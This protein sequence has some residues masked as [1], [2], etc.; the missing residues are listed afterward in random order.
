MA[1]FAN[2]NILCSVPNTNLA[3]DTF[4]NLKQLMK[5]AGWT[6]LSSSDGT[7][8]SSSADII[9][10]AGSGANGMNNNNAWFR[11][12]D[13][14]LTREFVFQNKPS[15]GTMFAVIKYSRQTKFNG[16]TPSA[17][18][19]PTTGGGDGVVILGSGGDV[20]S[21]TAVAFASTSGSAARIHLI[22]ESSPINGVYYWHLAV[23]QT[24]T[25]TLLSFFAHDYVSP[26][27]CSDNDND[28]SYFV[29][30]RNFTDFTYNLMSATTGTSVGA[31]KCWY[32]YGL[33][34]S[35]FDGN[36]NVYGGMYGTYTTFN[37]ASAQYQMRVPSYGPFPLST[38]PYDNKDNIIPLPIFSYSSTANTAS[39]WKGLSGAIKGV[40]VG[41]VYPEL[42][43]KGSSSSYLYMPTFPSFTGTIVIPWTTDNVDPS[44]SS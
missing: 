41:R 29:C 5:S 1:R 40:F 24:T 39:F 34:G 17:T 35:N 37:A 22:C 6:V 32:K 38:S 27:S 36:N 19:L 25:S 4:Y 3:A 44:T 9:S 7:T 11:I 33:A 14:A 28:P 20:A 21:P 23:Y 26:G 43:D 2:V 13:P 10:S 16:G 12:T 31:L 18:N 30:D 15:S 8:Y 42:L